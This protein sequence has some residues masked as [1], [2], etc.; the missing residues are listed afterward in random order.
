[1][2]VNIKDKNS[3]PLFSNKDVHSALLKAGLRQNQRVCLM[4]SNLLEK[5]EQN[6]T[7]YI[8]NSNGYCKNQTSFKVNLVFRFFKDFVFVNLLQ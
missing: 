4:V 6:K 5:I 3:E 8:F 1:M 7:I 2:S